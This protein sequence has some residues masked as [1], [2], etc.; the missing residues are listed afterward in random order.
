[1]YF[2]LQKV[3]LPNI[4]LCTEEQLYFRTQGGKYNYTSRN[5]LVPRHK[6]AYF[7][8]FFN[9]FS[10]KKWKKYTTLT[11]LFLRVNIIGR[12]TITVRHKENGVIRVLKQIDFKSSCN[13]SDEIEI[14]I[15]KINFGYIYVE[16][17]SDED[18]VLNG[19]EFLTKDHVS[20]S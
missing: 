15:S 18:S 16:W 6:V 4:D 3:I 11:S 17:Q 7:D 13:I 20:K 10:I 5:L 12:G 8:T 2:L 14:D 19:F 1:M 9:A